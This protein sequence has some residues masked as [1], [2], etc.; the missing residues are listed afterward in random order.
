M[1]LNRFVHPLHAFG[2]N[3]AGHSQIQADKALGVSYEQ[4]VAAFEEDACFVG[5]EI[6]DIDTCKE[7]PSGRM[8]FSG[9]SD[10]GM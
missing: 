4:A 7:R 6:G 3:R 9:L 8:E 5:K 2:D 1:L 10:G